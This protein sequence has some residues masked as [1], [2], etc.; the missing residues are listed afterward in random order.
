MAEIEIHPFQ[1]SQLDD[2]IEL[3]AQA[4]ATN[5]L[6]VVMFRGS[7]EAAIQ[8]HRTLFKLSLPVLYTGTKLVALHGDTVVGF[9]HWI[10]YPGCRPAPE[11]LADV[12]P[13]LLGELDGEVASRL[14]VWRRAWG[15]A[16]PDEPHSHFGPLAVHPEAQGKGI[17]GLLLDRYCAHLDREG[18]QGYLETERLQNLSIYRKAG[19]KVT[20]ETDVHGLPSWFMTRPAHA[21][22]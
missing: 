12:A 8:A 15:E 6:H 11:A 5:P 18:E 22:S 9:A 21:R 4:Y 2:V 20:A 19:F 3:L 14:L 17:G 7:D 16:D 1:E 13:K 10:P